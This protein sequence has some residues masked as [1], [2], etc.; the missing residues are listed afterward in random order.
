MRLTVD[1]RG[2]AIEAAAA[3]RPQA[4]TPRGVFPFL[5]LIYHRKTDAPSGKNGVGRFRHVTREQDFRI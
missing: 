2:A 5:R 4:P 1:I 3:K